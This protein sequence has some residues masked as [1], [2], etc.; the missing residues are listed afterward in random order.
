MALLFRWYLGMASRWAV[1]GDEERKSDYQIWCGPAMGA[2][3]TWARGSH[4]EPVEGRR[5]GEVA[6]QLMRG[7]AF[8]SRVHQLA[9]AGV[10]LPASSTNYRPQS[11]GAW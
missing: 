5:V 7:A 2:F 6:G 8:T 3:N 9:L 10:R 4:L 1:T 11:G